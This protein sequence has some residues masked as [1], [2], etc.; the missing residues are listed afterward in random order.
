MQIILDYI[1]ENGL[2]VIKRYRPTP[3]GKKMLVLLSP[4]VTYLYI[5]V[6]ESG[7]SYLV[8]QSKKFFRSKAMKYFLDGN[9]DKVWETVWDW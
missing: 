3:S 5:S 9:K 4:D 6:L 7:N 1:D 8:Y 2:P